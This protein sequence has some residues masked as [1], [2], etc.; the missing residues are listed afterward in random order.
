[1]LVGYMRVASDSDR[2]TTDLQRDA[3]L[4]AGIDSRNL[5]E[6]R[7]SGAKDSRPGLQKALDFMKEGDSWGSEGRYYSWFPSTGSTV[8]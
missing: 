5:F 6:D 1:M 2:Q 7:M 8:I 3:L 4:N